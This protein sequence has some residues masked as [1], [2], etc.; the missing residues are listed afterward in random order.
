MGSGDWNDGMN[1]VGIE[2]RGES[3]WLGW[4]L[5]ATLTRFA[6]LCDGQGDKEQA[7]NYRQHAGDLSKAIE[8]NAW[9]G[10]WY[11]RAYYDDG[12]PLG[13]AADEECQI[14]SIA[15]SWAVLSEAGD[16][17]RVAQAMESVARRLVRVDDQLLLLLT[18]PFD[19]TPRIWVISKDTRRH[20]ENGG[21]YTHGALWTVWAFAK[22]G[23]GDRAESC[24][25]C[26]TRSTTA[27]RREKSHGMGGAVCRRVKCIQRIGTHRAWGLDVVQRFRRMDVST[28]TRSDPGRLPVEEMY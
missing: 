19:K 11:R 20:R 15:Q 7:A 6:E 4:F 13:S 12:T 1:R 23:Q 14:D 5:Y 26:S 17:A 27:I 28:G 21:Q 3:V 25:I 24:S 18:P 22:L 9:D 10:A 16:R 2:G 8:A